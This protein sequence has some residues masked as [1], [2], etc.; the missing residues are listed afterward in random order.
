MVSS[1]TFS[2]VYEF[3]QK[4]QEALEMK[5]VSTAMSEINKSHEERKKE[6]DEINRQV[7]KG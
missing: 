6:T 2:S 3:P 5:G 1:V 7:Y 4:A